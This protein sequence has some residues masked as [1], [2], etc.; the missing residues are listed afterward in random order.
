VRD[1]DTYSKRVTVNSKTSQS[2]KVQIEASLVAAQQIRADPELL[3][4]IMR[5]REIAATQTLALAGA[6][7]GETDP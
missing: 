6:D 1:P 2:I 3:D 4:A 7:D 5:A